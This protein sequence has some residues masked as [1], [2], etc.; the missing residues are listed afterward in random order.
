MFDNNKDK[1][2]ELKV[3]PLFTKADTVRDTVTGT[4]F[5]K[6]NWVE[7]DAE[8]ADRLLSNNMGV[9]ITNDSDFDVEDNETSENIGD[10]SEVPQEGEIFEDSIIEEE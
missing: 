8:V 7:V 6:N 3:G 1:K 5:N 2:V 4:V 9:L 10:D